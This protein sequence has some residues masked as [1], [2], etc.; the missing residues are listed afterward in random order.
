MSNNLNFFLNLYLS[1]LCELS[2][3]IQG[4]IFFK[5]IKTAKDRHEMTEKCREMIKILAKDF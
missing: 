2:G 5:N 1:F 3:E 4:I